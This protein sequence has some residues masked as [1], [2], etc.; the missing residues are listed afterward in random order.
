MTNNSCREK[1]KVLHFIRTLYDS[2]NQK[3]TAKV[4]NTAEKT[5]EISQQLL[6]Q[7]GTDRKSVV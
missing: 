1:K 2:D 7:M 6:N 4:A 3:H 5:R